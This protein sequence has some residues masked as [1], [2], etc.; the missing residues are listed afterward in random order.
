[1]CST[2]KNTF[3]RRVFHNL[4]GHYNTYWNGNESF[5]QGVRQLN[6]TVQDNYNKILPVFNYGTDAEAQG[7]NSQ[8]DRAI[9]K[10]SINI[11][12]HSMYFNRKEYVKW[13]DDSYLMI[14]KAYFYKHEYNKARRTFEFVMNE[15]KGNAI[16][17][18]S[19]LWL[20]NSLIRLKK[21]NRAQ[22]IMDNLQ[23]DINK[24]LKIPRKV[25]EFLP[26]MKA[27]L[28]ISQEKFSQA[29]SQ[30]ETALYYRYDKNLS[31][32]IRFI[33]GQINQKEGEFYIAS[34]Y[35]LQVIK[36]NPAYVMAFNAGINLAQCY[37]TRYGDS[38]QIEKKL[39]KMLKEDKNKDFRDQIYFALADIAFKNSNDTLAIDYLRLSVASGLTN[40]YQ[41]SKSSLMLGDLFFERQ[42]YELSQAYYD[43][44]MQ[45]LPQDYP[46]YKQIE[47][48]TTYL[49]ELVSHLIVI[50]TEDSLQYVASLG[51]DE[52]NA[53]IDK[54]IEDKKIEEERLKEEEELMAMSTSNLNNMNR[55][56]LSGG[57]PM[58]SPTGTGNWYFYNPAALSQG[59]TEFTK[60]WGRRKLEDNWRLSNKKAAFT[61][62]ENLIAGDSLTGDSTMIVSTDPFKRETYLQYLPLTE[63]KMAG[64]NDRIKDALYNLGFIYKDKLNNMPRSVESF[65]KL[66]SRFPDNP[67]LLETYYHLYRLHTGL[68]NF[69]TA[70]QYK[71]LII[72]KYPD[73]DYARLLLDPDYFRELEARKNLALS[74]YRETW[75]AF[76][77][78]QYYTVIA[79]S[80]RAFET[81]SEPGHIFPKFAYL[82]ALAI[83]KVDVTDS[84][85]A[86]LETLLVKYPDSDVAPLAQNIVAYLKGPP[87]DTNDV[88][89]DQ[90]ETIYDLSIY[91]FRPSSGH[92][93]TLVTDDAKVNIEALKVKISDFNSKYYSIENLSITNVILSGNTHLIMSGNFENAEKAMLYYNMILKNEYVF[94]SLSGEDYDA[95]VLSQENY[96]V[97][98]KDKDIDKYIAFFAEKYLK[99]NE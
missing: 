74:L 62:D 40:N 24:N 79:N 91:K 64:S 49:T 53:L 37:D 95:F 88:Q 92:F 54:I 43:T 34:D 63:E 14:G 12:R 81:F 96:P 89:P 67:H 51:E 99:E 85:T 6:S 86:S 57:P 73:S 70:E 30:L 18:E 65:E 69:E 45:V 59:F 3:T 26:L 98:Y 82:R 75:D 11:Q 5:R 28:F 9:E 87:A 55:G 38:K 17:Y 1:S 42:E 13:I 41:K 22:S 60:K 46:N 66:I 47:A 76:E 97:F 2:K 16:T 56:G 32:R 33:L 10:A 8:M 77:A 80:N 36:K 93:F 31:A 29:K 50:K 25:V 71:N 61:P 52:R 68:G 27:D 20:A 39:V 58:G 83:G 21:Y 78:G 84:L 23:N 48:K 94:S 44:A 7:L 15:Y 35:Y 90:P 4:T 19:T 72:E